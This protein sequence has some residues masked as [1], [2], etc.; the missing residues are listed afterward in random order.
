[1]N[2][3]ME[4]VEVASLSF[5]L[6]LSPSLVTQRLAA[7]ARTEPWSCGWLCGP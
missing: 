3:A 1:M 7:S 6:V 5:P 4:L 2:A